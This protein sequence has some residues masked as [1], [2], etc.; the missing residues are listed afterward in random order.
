MKY[1][2]LMKFKKP[3]LSFEL[4]LLFLLFYVIA[5]FAFEKSLNFSLFGDDWL[6]LYVINKTYG[7][8][9]PYPYF[10]IKGYTHLWGFMNICLI[11]VHHFFDYQSYYY[12]VI[13]LLTRCLASLAGYI[14]FYNFSKSKVLAITGGFFVLVGFAGLESTST[15]AFINVY[16]LLVFLFL[17]LLFLISSYKGVYGVIKF[18]IGAFFYGL[19]LMAAPIRSQGL[20]PFILAFELIYGVKKEKIRLKYL[21]FRITLLVIVTLII[22]KLGF[23]GS[24]GLGGDWSFINIPKIRSMIASQ[25]F[26]FITTFVT[27]LGKTFLPDSYPMTIA[28]VVSLVGNSWF[29]A[30]TM[31]GFIFGCCLFWILSAAVKVD[32]IKSFLITVVILLLSFLA[33]VVVLR[34]F[35]RD[36]SLLVILVD[37]IIGVF[38]STFFLWSI[39]LLFIVKQK[40][41]IEG[42]VGG[43]LGPIFILTSIT[44]PLLFNPG[45][46]FGAS[47]R[48]LTLSL[49]GSSITIVSILIIARRAKKAWIFISLFIILLFFNIASDRK[50]FSDLYPYRNTQITDNMWNQV[51][52]AVPREVYSGRFLL[53]Y[54]DDSENARLAHNTILFGFNPR[55]ALEYGIKD[56]SKTPAYTNIYSEVVSAV[57]DGKVFKRLGYKVERI[58]IN[59]IYAFKITKDGKLI[60]TTFEV[61]KDLVNKVHKT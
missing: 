27:N 31:V 9:N 17:S 40:D 4:I 15:V 59:Q 26:T 60:D 37:S 61:R 36:A 29:R 30:I 7:F 54:F 8:G 6:Q 12:F 34:I 11:I 18:L 43:I 25:D 5:R 53:F 45:A 19:S 32:R 1:N 49:V 51:F 57:T 28:G 46:V 13:S 3:L 41:L 16:L 14:F 55:M 58:D 35:P 42:S 39:Y 20:F 23:F 24:Y 33:V 22:Y 47:H 10:T 38:I 21:F 2:I 44:V 52:R 48:Y 50:Y 56:E